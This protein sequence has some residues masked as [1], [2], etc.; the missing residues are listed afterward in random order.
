[1]SG[2][3]EQFAE[4]V[5][6]PVDVDSLAFTLP[7]EH[8]CQD[9]LPLWIKPVDDAKTW[10]IDAPVS[11]E[12]LWEIWHDPMVNRAN[13]DVLDE[14]SLQSEIELYRDA[15]GGTIIDVTPRELYCSD[16]P[17][18]LRRL[19]ERTG[20][21]IVAST[22]HYFRMALSPEVANASSDAIAESMVGDSEIGIDGTGIRPGMIKVAASGDI[23]P[24]EERL[25]RAAAIA[26]NRTGLAI[27][28]HPPSFHGAEPKE[29]V[30][31]LDRAGANLDRVIIAHAHVRLRNAQDAQELM[32][33]GV[34]LTYDGFGLDGLFVDSYQTPYAPGEHGWH[35]PGDIETV[36]LVCQL[37][38]AGYANRLMLSHDTGFKMTFAKYGGHGFTH[39]HRHVVR[40]LRDRGASDSDIETMTIRNPRRLLAID[41]P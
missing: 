38:D 40:Y 14:A 31:I 16:H 30:E 39:I 32:D 7:H 15:G 29:V 36:E 10:L 25:L 13:L 8:L 3:A 21:H 33:L 9:L 1:M 11:A 17:N 22:G 28:V 6:G 23:Y 5:L 20:V 12:N 19:S 2:S 18:T 27:T 41:A 35:A 37:L 34:N 26:Q 4:T 24:E